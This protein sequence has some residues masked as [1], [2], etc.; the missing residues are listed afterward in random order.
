MHAG[1]IRNAVIAPNVRARIGRDGL[2]RASAPAKAVASIASTG[3]AIQTGKASEV[4]Q[5]RHDEVVGR[6]ARTLSKWSR[7]DQLGRPAREPTVDQVAP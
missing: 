1:Q 2:N 5:R 7:S 4:E 6:D 3:T